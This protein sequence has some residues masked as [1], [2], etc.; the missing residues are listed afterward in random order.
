MSCTCQ[1]GPVEI[2]SQSS[3][4][5]RLTNVFSGFKGWVGKTLGTRLTP[6][7]KSSQSSSFNPGL[8]IVKFA[9]TNFM[10][11]LHTLFPHFSSQ[12][13]SERIAKAREALAFRFKFLKFGRRF[14]SDYLAVGSPIKK[15]RE[16]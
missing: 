16:C 13:R 6:A 15:S 7:H 3:V 1:A 14:T 10:V 4:L 5:L 11:R 8:T 2:R 9:V 12:R